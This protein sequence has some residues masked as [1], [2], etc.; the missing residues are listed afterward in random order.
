M[1]QRGQLVSIA[2]SLYSRGYTFGTAGN[3]SVRVGDT[4]I[5]SPTNSS[6]GDLTEEACA[7][8]ELNGAVL[9]GPQPSKEVPFHLAA[10][11]A[12][13][14][15][16]AVV[17]LHSCHATALSCLDDLDTGDAMPVFT[18]YYA[19]RLPCLPVVGYFPPGDAALGPAV[20]AAAIKS[21]AMLLRNH[22][23][24]TIGR[25]LMEAAGL[26]EEIEEQARL[27]FLLGSRGRTLTPAQIAEL[28]R[29]FQ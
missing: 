19:M 13:P 3:L 27:F 12:R 16:H 9:A 21:P 11:R 14:D 6:F 7:E 29:R 20:E 5:I 22:G 24:I 18:P 2:R 10:Y 26:A 25:T 4:V 1:S 8:V 23:S 28:R 17:H 15:A